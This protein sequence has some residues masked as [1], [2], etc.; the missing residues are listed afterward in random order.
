MN[1]MNSISKEMVNGKE[2]ENRR[3]EESRGKK[4]KG[5]E[6]EVITHWC[7]EPLMKESGELR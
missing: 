4:R 7:Q 2:E 3:E 6:E 5:I 1:W